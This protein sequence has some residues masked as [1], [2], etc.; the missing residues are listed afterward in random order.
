MDETG[1]TVFKRPDSHPC[2]PFNPHGN[3]GSFGA[4]HAAGPGLEPV[5]GLP[6]PPAWETAVAHQGLP[7]RRFLR[8]LPA[9]VPTTVSSGFY[10]DGIAQKRSC[11]DFLL[12]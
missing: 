1:R 9:A 4:P 11:C 3:E 2:F 10:E 8:P 7:P 5:D 6:A 12:T